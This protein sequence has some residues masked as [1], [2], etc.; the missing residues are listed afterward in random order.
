MPT[1]TRIRTLSAAAQQSAS[2]DYTDMVKVSGTDEIG[3]FGALYNEMASDLRQ[4]TTSAREREDVLRRYVENTTTD[5]GEPLADLEQRLGEALASRPDPTVAV[6]VKEAHR[7]VM[8]MRN[9]AAVIRLRS[10]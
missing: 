10:L 8:Q 7:L 2:R 6:A 9:Q 3:S 5:V 4:K 1:G